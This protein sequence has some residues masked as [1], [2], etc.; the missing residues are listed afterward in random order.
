MSDPNVIY[1]RIDLLVTA[2]DAAE[3]RAVK[4]EMEL[5]DQRGLVAHLR[6]VRAEHKAEV[7]RLREGIEEVENE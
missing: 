7:A 4:A 2:L 3:A 1:G 6:S 5:E